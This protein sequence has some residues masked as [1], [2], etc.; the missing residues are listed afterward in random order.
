MRTWLVRHLDRSIEPFSTEPQYDEISFDVDSVLRQF[1][2]LRQEVKLQTQAVRAALEQL[3]EPPEPTPEPQPGPEKSLKAIVDVHDSLILATSRVAQLRSDI[4]P[5][6][7]QLTT[8]VELPPK[9]DIKLEVTHEKRGFWGRSPSLEPVRPDEAWATWAAAVEQRLEERMTP[10]RESADFL[11]RSLEGM[12][13]GYQMGL[14]RL[15]RLLSESGLESIPT[16]G[17]PFDPELMEIAELVPS[18]EV[19]EP[20]VVEEVRRGYRLDGRMFR[21][22]QVKVAKPV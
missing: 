2:G 6:L 3:S 1:I 5:H 4:V 9:P 19:T 15:T 14:A 20:V 18:N 7:K 8:P 11:I 10:I 17:E 21:F 16:L 12:L 22:A 13:A